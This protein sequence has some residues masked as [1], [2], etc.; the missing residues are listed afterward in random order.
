VTLTPDH[1]AIASA[2]YRASQ[3]EVGRT[4]QHWALVDLAAEIAKVLAHDPKFDRKEFTE[5]CALEKFD[6]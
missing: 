6:D 5:T 1:R 4:A 2:I 3:C